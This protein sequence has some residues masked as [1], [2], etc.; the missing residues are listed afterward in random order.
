MAA[1]SL[2][3]DASQNVK[4]AAV[5]SFYM[6]AALVVRPSVS[7]FPKER[8]LIVLHTDGLCVSPPD[9]SGGRGL[10]EFVSQQ[11]SCA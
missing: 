2:I 6:A 4:V 5:V 1:P 9:T 3:Q 11:Q 8:V 7:F 10:I